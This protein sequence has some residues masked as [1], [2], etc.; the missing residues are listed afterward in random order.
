MWGP[1]LRFERFG[2][3]RF[4]M[5]IEALVQ[6]ELDGLRAA[7]LLRVP[8]VIDGAQGP[9]VTLDGRQA[10]CFC[11]NNY[12][13]LADHASIVAAVTK[14]IGALGF[15]ACASRHIT[16]TMRLH[17]ELEERMASFVGLER[18][19]FFPTG[20]AA[21]QGAVQA[22][23]TP[24]T[25][26]LSDER[27][28]ASIIDGC[29]LGRADVKVFRHADAEHVQELLAASRDRYELRL[30]VT[31]SVFSMDGDLA[32]LRR[33]R[34]LCDE[35][36]AALFVDD[37]HALGVMGEQGRGACALLGV[38]P[39]VLTATFGKALGCS[40][41]FVAASKSVVAW[42]E[43]RA[44]PHVFT[45]APS[46]ALPAAALAA[47]EL[48]ERADD[49]RSQLRENARVLRQGLV[50]LDYQVLGDT[51]IL[52]LPLGAAERA[53]QF[54]DKLLDLGVFVHAIRPPTVAR[55]TSRLRITPL[56][57]HTLEQI[58]T[59]L[60]AFAALRDEA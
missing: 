49:R 1:V 32:P 46:P 19:L 37:A 27:N 14:A 6:R 55:G 24:K 50:S 12:L 48:V 16:G 30:V 9:L 17:R 10:L 58:S 35:H 5:R 43:N 25:L 20:Y 42:I 39:D 53:T 8:R 4:R 59:V 41:A 45:T 22:L 52:P 23:A 29:R 7:G 44:R 13:G 40:G 60:Q 36:D 34:E 18:A 2:D 38:K 21:N 33:L 26:V 56:A 51:H 28:H 57:T 31:E 3:K 47:I 54:S 15:G 11:S